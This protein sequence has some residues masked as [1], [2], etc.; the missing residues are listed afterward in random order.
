MSGQNRE[1]VQVNY[2]SHQVEPC[3]HSRVLVLTVPHVSRAE[4]VLST[5]GCPPPPPPPP[6]CSHPDQ[7]VRSRLQQLHANSLLPREGAC[8]PRPRRC[9]R[10]PLRPPAPAPCGE[11]ASRSPAP[12]LSCCTWTPAPA[13]GR[14]PAPATSRQEDAELIDKTNIDHLLIFSCR[15][16]PSPAST[17]GRAATSSSS[18]W[19]TAATTTCSRSGSRHVRWGTHSWT[20]LCTNLY[21]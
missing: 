13:L 5:V 16:P 15:R 2:L 11:C 8:P 7:E 12:A 17:L 14:T 4:A 21:I 9:P 3:R 1:F 19:G 10:P 18:R 20:H 6:P